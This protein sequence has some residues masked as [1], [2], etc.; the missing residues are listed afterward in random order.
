[1]LPMWYYQNYIKVFKYVIYVKEEPNE[2]KK[3]D[4]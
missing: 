2:K 3:M 4:F 1:M